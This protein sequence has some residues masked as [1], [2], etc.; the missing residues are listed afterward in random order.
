MTTIDIN[1]NNIEALLEKFFD[2]NTTNAE[3]RALEELFCSGNE[4]PERYKHYCDMFGW[5]ASGMDTEKLPTACTRPKHVF[6]RSKAA[7]WWSS[8]AAVTALTVGIAWLST[9]QS[10]TDNTLLY[11]D[12]YIVRDGRTITGMPEIK[13]DID[14]SVMDGDC[15]E[16]EIDM[17]IR[18]LNDKLNE[19]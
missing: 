10:H 19:E 16:N 2:G 7:K 13:A 8:V 11:A 17:G 15:L 5:Y 12:N 14:A 9:W 6:F 3:D 4:V 1:E 18:M